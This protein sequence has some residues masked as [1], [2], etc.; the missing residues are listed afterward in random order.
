MSVYLDTS[1][2]IETNISNFAAGASLSRDTSK[3]YESLLDLAHSGRALRSEVL[4]VVSVV[5]V[6]FA[7]IYASHLVALAAV[8]SCI[9][10]IWK[11]HEFSCDLANAIRKYE[12]KEATDRSIYLNMYKYFNTIRAQKA[13]WIFK[14]FLD[15]HS[16]Y[17][18]CESTHEQITTS[19]QKLSSAYEA[20]TKDKYKSACQADWVAKLAA[21]DSFSPLGINADFRDCL[22]T[23]ATGS[24]FIQVGSPGRSGY[25]SR[26]PQFRQYTFSY[27]NLKGEKVTRQGER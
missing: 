5:T 16:G 14:K 10:S 2:S 9:I 24:N 1:L 3:A 26:P 23:L 4:L 27:V 25:S 6:I 8:G 22:T 12:T 11:R 17:G 13:E 20:E 15:Q 21:R 18:G 7:G 19:L